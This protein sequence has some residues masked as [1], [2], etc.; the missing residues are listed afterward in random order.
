MAM[1][2]HP[3]SWSTT[4]SAADFDISIDTKERTSARVIMR[5][6]TMCA[7][8]LGMTFDF[9]APELQ[10]SKEATKHTDMFAYVKTVLCLQGH[11]NS[12]AQ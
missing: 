9:A 11:C 10:S 7:T 4:G 2:N 8:A 5:S 12:G 3:T 6:M 1:S